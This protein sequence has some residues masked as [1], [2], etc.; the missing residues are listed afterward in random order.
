[1]TPVEF[2]RKHGTGYHGNVDRWVKTKPNSRCSECT[3]EKV[4]RFRIENKMV[5]K[6]CPSTCEFFEQCVAKSGE[7]VE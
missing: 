7:V 5:V 6:N 1:M 4:M 3:S 2:G